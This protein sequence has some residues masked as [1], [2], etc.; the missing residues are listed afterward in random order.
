MIKQKLLKTLRG[1]FIIRE[2]KKEDISQITNLFEIAFSKT[3]SSF[4]WYWKYNLNPFGTYSFVCI[5]SADNKVIVHAGALRIP[6]FC[7]NKKFFALQVVDCM[8]HPNLRGFPVKKRG[9]FVLT[10]DVLFDSVV[11]KQNPYVFGF[12]GER[13]FFLG[14][15]LLK[16]R[17]LAKPVEY[18]F[19]GKK[20]KTSKV[21][22]LSSKEF[23]EVVES[24]K[25]Y[26]KDSRFLDFCVLKSYNYLKWRYVDSPNNYK[27]YLIEDKS[28]CVVREIDDV[29]Y[30]I[31]LLNLEYL[32]EAILCLLRF[33]GRKLKLWLPQ[34]HFLENCVK[35]L[36][37]S[38][39]LNHVYPC[40]KI[41]WDK[42]GITK[43][44]T[45]FFY[46]MGDSDL[47]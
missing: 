35:D 2:A 31:D 32:R 39:L 33:T 8:S 5:K 1:N 7:E 4:W 24:R 38:L 29:Y 6:I 3:H 9:L 43:P 25:F 42:F 20:K 45:S 14:N 47:F 13:H 30:V 26:L 46:L 27:F 37:E 36:G 22:E 40:E 10:M 23:L 19:K 21:K 18:T 16:Y 28:I 41:F 15:K 11:N 34:G 17:Q 12:A 44:K